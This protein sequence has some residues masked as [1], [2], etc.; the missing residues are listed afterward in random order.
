MRIAG[1]QRAVTAYVCIHKNW[2]KLFKTPLRMGVHP[3]PLKCRR[4]RQK[5]R[6]NAQGGVLGDMITI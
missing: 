1:D 5:K 3:S 2:L 4:P 6:K